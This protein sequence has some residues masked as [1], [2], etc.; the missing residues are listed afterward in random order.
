MRKIYL[1]DLGLLVL[2]GTIAAALTAKPEQ[3]GMSTEQ[4]FN[5]ELLSCVDM[6]ERIESGCD[7]V[8]TVPSADDTG[9]EQE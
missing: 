2:A 5:D 1:F 7:L 9:L 6:P 4:A 8:R 3:A